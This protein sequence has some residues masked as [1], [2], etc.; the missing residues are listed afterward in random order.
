[1]PLDSKLRKNY[2]KITEYTTVKNS[3]ESK[4]NSE[5]TCVHTI[6]SQKRPISPNQLN[7][8]VIS[9]R[10]KSEFCVKMDHSSALN[11]SPSSNQAETVSKDENN[12]DKLQKVLKSFDE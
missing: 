5:S 2:K 9:K 7:I 1:M 12:C 11:L 6:K 10:T 4:K 8:T 3:S